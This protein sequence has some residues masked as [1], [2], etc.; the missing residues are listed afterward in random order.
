MAGEAGVQPELYRADYVIGPVGD[1]PLGVIPDGAIVTGGDRILFA[2]PRA[3]G[4][5]RFPGVPRTDYG[6]AVISPGFVNA[7]MHLYGVLA[8]GLKAPAPIRSFEGFLGDYWWPL[9]ENQLDPPML[10]AAAE[11]SGLELIDS[12]VTALCD[13]MEAPLAPR[14]GL[15][16]Q[17][18]VLERLGVRAVLSVEASERISPQNGRLCLRE[19]GEFLAARR[20]HPRVSA[21]LCLHTAFTCS[22][23][24]IEEALGLAEDLDADIQVHL[25]ESAYEPAWCVERLGKRTALWYEELGL[26]SGRLI[27]A[28]C[29]QLS[30]E[31]IDA[32]ARAGVRPVHVPLS[33]CEV[34]GGIAPAPALLDRGLPLALGTDGYI[35]NFFA[36]M[37]GAFLIHKGY[38]QS[39]DVM[40]AKTVWNM[41]TACGARAVFGDREKTGTLAPGYGADFIVISI[42]D[43]P[44]EISPENLFEQLVLYRNPPDVRDV[45][46]AGRALKKDGVLRTGDK[47]EAAGR[48]R[49][50]SAR[51]REAGLRQV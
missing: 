33:N 7:H 27:A 19:N 15:E 25:N 46:A 2:G 28:Q 31:E 42:G 6:P 5:A 13:C 21:S 17:A 34:G 24:F 20:N 10:A 40:S 48:S 49:R 45:F 8:H 12:G 35:N 30:P 44:S 14:A 16:A 37:R 22:R 29:V 4:E 51:L 23:S 41:A 47:V 43:I 18:A 11:C 50:E 32:L 3:A 9:V 26:L 38:L 36:V 1:D 39:A